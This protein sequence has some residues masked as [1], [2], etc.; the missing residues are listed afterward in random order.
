MKYLTFT[1]F[2]VVFFSGCAT[3]KG[4]K[5]D[6]EDAWDVTKETSVKAYK[7]TKKV[8]NEATAD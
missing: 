8:I 1:L 6:S 3:W 2:C 4:V 5:Q 7:S